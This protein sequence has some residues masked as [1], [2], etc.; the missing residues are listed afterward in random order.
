MS[1]NWLPVAEALATMQRQIK[2]L[3]ETESIALHQALDRIAAAPVTAPLDVPGYDNSAMDGYAMRAKDAAA[4]QP[5]KVVG[6]AFAGHPYEGELPANSCVRIMT[7][8][9]LPAAADTV[10]MQEQVSRE[11][12]SIRCTLEPKAGDNVRRRGSD[13]CEGATVIAQGQRLSAVDI[14]LLASL[15]KAEVTV[16]RRLR[17][18]LF[19]NGDELVL[20][21]EELPSASHIYDSNRFTLHA[22]LQRL[23]VEVIDLGLIADDREALEHAFQQAMRRADVLISS[24]GV[25]VGDADYTKEIMESLGKIGFWKI[26]MKPGKPFAFGQLEDTWFFGLPGNPVAAVVTMDQIVQP[27][28][29]RLAG[30]ATAAPMQLQARAATTVK[31]KPGRLDFQRGRFEQRDG[32]IWAEPIGSQSSAVL[33]SVAQANCFLVLEQDRASVAVGETITIQPFDSLLT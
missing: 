32:E 18:A 25:S 29:R 4:E 17:V 26:A 28:L 9:Q 11:G 6:T 5:L 27:M 24:A 21:G 22:M 23:G 12:D 31:K 1:P 14:G 33:T 30:E 3:Q 7:G 8:A 10:V 16:V 19:S 2:P 15:G 20:P 13:I